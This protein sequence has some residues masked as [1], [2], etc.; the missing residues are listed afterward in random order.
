MLDHQG[1]GIKQHPTVA[2]AHLVL[3]GELQA[4][5]GFESL[6]V[7]RHVCDGDGWVAEHTCEERSGHGVS[8]PGC[9]GHGGTVVK[10]HDRWAGLGECHLPRSW[11]M[12]RKS[13]LCGPRPHAAQGSMVPVSCGKDGEAEAASVAQ[14]HGARG[15]VL[16]KTRGPNSSP[17][18]FD[19]CCM[20]A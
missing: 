18:G 19:A 8:R 15:A 17:S 3:L 13:G 20:H 10:G 7:L 5:V 6:H 14:K 11:S 4:V 1:W 16:P 12:G 2:S 9:C